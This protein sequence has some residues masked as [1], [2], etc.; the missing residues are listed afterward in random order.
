MTT[1]R[2]IAGERKRGAV[3]TKGQEYYMSLVTFTLKKLS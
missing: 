2:L 3:D 1:K